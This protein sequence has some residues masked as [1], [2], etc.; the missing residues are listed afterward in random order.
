M[1][2][3][4][5]IKASEKRPSRLIVTL[6]DASLFVIW[7][8]T[9]SRFN[10][11]KD[12]NIEEAEI[13]EVLSYDAYLSL[14]NDGLNY[15]SYSP[16]TESQLR[17]KLIDKVRKYEK[18]LRVNYDEVIDKIIEE[19]KT[20]NYINDEQ[21]ANDYVRM[22]LSRKPKSRILLLGELLQKGVKKDIAERCLD[23]NMPENSELIESV[24]KRKY[25]DQPI[26]FEDSKKVGYL[27]RQGFLWDDISEFINSRKGDRDDI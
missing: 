3:I 16:R 25:G 24:Y 1:P 17:K 21:Y 26:S 10:I 20:N 4:E 9:L 8:D 6:D 2:K 12:K 13:G 14:K 27:Q 22:K 5:S 19:C 23:E 11:Y 18:S 7:L 15:L